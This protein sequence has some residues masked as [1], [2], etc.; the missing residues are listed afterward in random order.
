V[1][2]ARA[3]A[4]ERADVERRGIRHD[5]RF[6]V[7]DDAG[8]FVSQRTHPAMARVDVRIEGHTL[9][10]EASAVGSVRVPLVPT[11]GET[12]RVQIWDDTC[13]ALDLGESA[14]TFFATLL[15]MRCA[16]VY[17]PETSRRQVELPYGA[18]GDLASF[19]DAY[20]LLVTST[21]SLADLNTRLATPVP[22]NRFRPNIVIDDAAPF[23][24]DA[25]RKVTFGALSAR[26]VKPCQRCAVVTVDQETGKKGVEPLKTLAEFRKVNNAVLFGQNVIPDGDGEIRVGDAVTIVETLAR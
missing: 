19:A 25:W 23:A 24:E 4:L 10:I 16:L 2:G 21:S 3:I 13:D 18:L 9:A 17:M 12:R 26:V 14:S 7:V 20:P 5:R 1:K 15:G 22:M 8:K 11:S 6:M